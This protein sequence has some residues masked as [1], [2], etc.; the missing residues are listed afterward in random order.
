MEEEGGRKDREHL[1]VHC[2]AL[3]WRNRRRRRWG[4]RVAV[5]YRLLVLRLW[6]LRLLRLRGI[7]VL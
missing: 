7:G 6:L 1:T 5:G 2:I 3:L 4:C